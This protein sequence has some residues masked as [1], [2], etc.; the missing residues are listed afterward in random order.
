MAPH[1]RTRCSAEGAN[2]R[3]PKKVEVD[4]TSIVHKDSANLKLPSTTTP[5]KAGRGAPS[6][7]PVYPTKSPGRRRGIHSKSMDGKGKKERVSQVEEHTVPWIA[8]LTTY[9]GYAV[10]ILFGYVRDSL[11]FMMSCLYPSRFPAKAPDG[12]APLFHDF[13]YFYTRRMYW[14]IQDCF[15]RPI[16]SA[17]GAWIDVMNREKSADHSSM[18]V[19]EGVTTALN[20]S[21]YNYLGFAEC[22][23][24]MRDEVVHAV[25]TYGVANC[26]SR[27]ELGTTEV[28]RELEECIAGFVGKE[29]ALV[30]GMGFATNSTVL[31]AIIGPGGLIISDE[32]N[33][34]SIVNGARG[35]GAKIK[36]FKHNSAESLEK[37]LRESISEGQP[38]T[39]RPWTKIIVVVE[40]LYSMEG[41]ICNLKPIVEVC[42]RYRAY[43]YVD[44]AH[45][46][47]ALGATG[48]GVLEHC[49]VEPEDVDIMM[50]TFTK[51]FGSVGGYI[52]GSRELVELLRRVCPGSTHACSMAP[53][54]A[55]QATLALRMIMGADGTSKGR[56]KIEQLRRNANM[57]RVGLERMGC[58]VLGDMDS[59]VV[60]VMLY[61][62]SKIPAFSRECLERKLAVVVVGFP[63][64]PLIKSRVRFCLSAAHSEEDLIA[65]LKVVSEVSERV[66]I[67]YKWSGKPNVVPQCDLNQNREHLVNVVGEWD[68]QHFGWR[69]SLSI[70]S[71]GRFARGNG[72]EGSWHVRVE[73]AKTILRLEWD[74]WD[75]E[76]LVLQA[77]DGDAVASPCPSPR[78]HVFKGKARIMGETP[79]LKGTFTLRP[80]EGRYVCD[81]GDG[82]HF[83]FV[84]HS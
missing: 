41:E 2:G 55:K 49:G 27:T 67:K 46:I 84:R 35:S 82:Q 77:P 26:S 17:P 79:P 52:A 80:K 50:G 25:R 9:F 70:S 30:I 78:R 71:S 62:P 60:P 8:A 57:F 54:C 72:D 7:L 38:R 4:P 66:M 29:A 18:S 63:A 74:R 51:S 59:P 3:A 1:Q 43:V 13:Q 44:E 56:D 45:S 39:R 28:H 47:G 69:D 32:L 20:L 40:G 12:Y 75:S 42:K 6:S 10:L 5:G 58:E 36:V 22:D 64:T 11:E 15:N 61:N 37:I 31:P 33:H 24:E 48:R 68:A 53:G 73:G 19:T 14:R 16:S 76:E 21:S 81:G 23:L 65:A 34:S 83:K